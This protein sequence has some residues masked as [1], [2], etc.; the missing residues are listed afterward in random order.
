M[1]RDVVRGLS[2]V[3][4]FIHGELF[5]HQLKDIPDVTLEANGTLHEVEVG[6][7]HMCWVQCV[8]MSR[9]L[10]VM[11][12]FYGV[13]ITHDIRQRL[14]HDKVERRLRHFFL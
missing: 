5:L 7:L 9:I 11:N 12:V 6:G 2:A 4:V 8:D 1:L 3:R 14:S 13:I 10:C